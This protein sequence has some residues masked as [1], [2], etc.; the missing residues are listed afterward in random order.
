MA[1]MAILPALALRFRR[2]F[3]AGPFAR[4]GPAGPFLPPAVCDPETAPQ[5]PERLAWLRLGEE[6]LGPGEVDERPPEVDE[7]DGACQLPD[8]PA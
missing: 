2:P 5:V 7:G 1:K 8:L 6:L 3:G 4:G